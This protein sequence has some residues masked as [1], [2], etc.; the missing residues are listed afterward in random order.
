MKTLA[1]KLPN[2]R[3]VHDSVPDM[4]KTLHLQVQGY[5]RP[6]LERVL[7]AGDVTVIDVG[8]NIG[9]FALEVLERTGGRARLHCF[10]PIPDTFAL[11]QMNLRSFG[12]GRVSAHRLAL[13]RAP[14]TAA[15]HYSRRQSAISSMYDMMA[16]EDKE[17][18]LAAIYDA[19]IRDKHHA[20]LPAIMGYLPRSVNSF[21]IDLRNWWM[22]RE[23][24]RV[25]CQITT[26]SDFIDR[27]QIE[28]VDVLKI[29]VEKAEI[30]VLE[31]IRPGDWDK[32]RAVAL[33]L[34]DFEGRGERVRRMLEGHGFE[35]E[36]DRICAE[37]VLINVLGYR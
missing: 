26:L 33:E 32:I 21:L 25:V 19:R 2:Q 10:E 27:E 13:G 7:A 28:R 24:E 34:H 1:I 37:D 4:A 30:D 17:A 18:T 6:R 22:K 36:T 8:A 23:M 9:M 5:F 16:N 14:G 20:D 29:D 35:V 11:L 15:F 3:V 12:A 31:G